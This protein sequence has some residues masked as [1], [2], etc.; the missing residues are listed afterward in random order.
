MTKAPQDRV[1]FRPAKESC[2]WGI[3][4]SFFGS[5]SLGMINHRGH[6]EECVGSKQKQTRQV[7]ICN[8]QFAVFNF[9]FSF[10]IFQFAH[11]SLC[12][13]WLIV[14]NRRDFYFVSGLDPG[15]SS[16]RYIEQICKTRRLQQAGGGARAISARAN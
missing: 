12:P 7:A 4:F 13:L 3:G 16:A 11:S 2:V 8:L 1:T 5:S 14:L 10:F 15:G 6:R 9:H